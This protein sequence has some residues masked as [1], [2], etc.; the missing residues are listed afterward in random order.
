M[1]DKDEEEKGTAP[2]KSRGGDE[3][4]GRRERVMARGVGVREKSREDKNKRRER[5]NFC[6]KI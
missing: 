5:A 4:N 6:T 3:T 2:T 1:G